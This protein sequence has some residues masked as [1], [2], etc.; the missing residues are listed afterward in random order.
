MGHRLAESEGEQAGY[1]LRE[2]QLLDPLEQLRKVLAEGRGDLESPVVLGV[3]HHHLHLFLADRRCD[4]EDIELEP[5]H[6]VHRDHLVHPRLPLE[7]IELHPVV[8]HNHRSLDRP[9]L[10]HILLPRSGLSDPRLHPALADHP[11]LHLPEQ[12]FAGGL[13]HVYL[14]SRDCGVLEYAVRGWEVGNL[15]GL[16]VVEEQARVSPIPDPLRLLED[17]AELDLDIGH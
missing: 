9:I 16:A 7:A 17:T 2:G 11:E 13:R 12:V 5:V 3:E 14:F 10:S 6:C 4:G 8:R 15:V 1:R